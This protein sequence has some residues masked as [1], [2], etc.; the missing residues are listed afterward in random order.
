MNI[1]SPFKLDNVSFTDPKM[2]LNYK[3]IV[4]L[5]NTEDDILVDDEDDPEYFPPTVENEV[6]IPV[7]SESES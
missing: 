4:D 6:S 3:Q 1:Y 7:A 5:L 2:K